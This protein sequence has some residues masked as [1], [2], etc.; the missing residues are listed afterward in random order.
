MTADITVI[1]PSLP[2]RS[3]LLGQAIDS[4]CYQDLAPVAHLVGID[5]ARRGPAAVRQELVEAA[6]TEWVAFL[7]DDDRLH[8]AHLRLLHQVAERT[9]ADV[10]IP[11]CRFE[12]PPLPA[13]YC[14]QPFD[15]DRLRDHGIFPITVLARRPAVLTAGGFDPADR[16]EDW[17]LWNRMADNGCRFVDLDE[18]TWTYRTSTAD[19]RTHA[20]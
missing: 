15:R 4:V 14:N 13:K 2:E 6:T 9:V 12:G 18:T 8:D 16:Y 11:R 5:H 3:G 1:T 19:R 7:D 10:V 20:A 17:A